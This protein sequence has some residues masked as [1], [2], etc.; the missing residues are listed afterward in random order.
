MPEALRD[1][2]TGVTLKIN[3]TGS[4]NVK[5]EQEAIYIDDVS[6]PNVIY[7]GYSLPGVST[8]SAVWKI[9]T[10]DETGSFL[11]IK[12]ASGNAKYD[13]KWTLRTT[14]VYS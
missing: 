11:V 5:M 10:L 14:Y 3:D 8:A 13:K 9:K 1:Q 4:I 2:N 6:T 12:Y 7:L